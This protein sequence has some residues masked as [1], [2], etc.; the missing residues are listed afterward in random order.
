MFGHRMGL[1]SGWAAF[2]IGCF[3]LVGACSG[4]SDTSDEAG[5]D[6]CLD[7]TSQSCPSQSSACDDLPAC[8]T[9]RSCELACAQ[10]DSGCQNQCVNAAAGDTDAILA[11]ANLVACAS[12]PCS[13]ACW[14]SSSSGTS[15]GTGTGG[16]SGTGATTGQGGTTTITGGVTSTG[17]GGV[18]TPAQCQDLLQWATGCAV[19]TDPVF[20]NCNS[21]PPSGCQT[22]CYVNASCDEYD[23][24]KTGAANDLST[25]L[26]AC[27]LAGGTTL[28]PTCANAQA[29]Y[30]LCG[31]STSLDCDDN[32]PVDQCLSKCKLDYPCDQWEPPMGQPPTAYQNCSNGCDASVGMT[33]PNFDVSE[34]GYVTTLTWHGYAWTATDGV[35]ASTISPADFSALPAGQQ[36]CASGTVA[37][38]AD[39]SAVAMLGFSLSQDEGDPAPDPGTWSPL[40]DLQIGGLTYNVTNNTGTP[41]RIQIQ[42]PDGDTDPTQR[43]CAEIIGQTGSI[44]WHTFNTQCWEGGAGTAYNGIDALESI[45]VLVP[46][47]LAARA[48]DFCIY[49]ILED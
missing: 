4:S 2:T 30:L 41:L 40:D 32:D 5:K 37:G 33:S 8:K 22:S 44:F 23:A 19:D 31:F 39:Y 49:E 11:A 25:C 48:F 35:S 13:N 47:D 14:G 45:M 9:L 38:T 10:N 6:A 46:G 7:C 26:T 34:G 24:Y 18:T 3:S 21:A 17:T 42:G 12:T 1:I 29:K 27:D 15:G 16:S 36:L 28:P 20:R 43:W